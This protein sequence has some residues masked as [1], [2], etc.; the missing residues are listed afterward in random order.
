MEYLVRTRSE[1]IRQLSEL[2]PAMGFILA[3]A[4]LIYVLVGW[5]VFRVLII[6]NCAALGASIGAG[7]GGMLGESVLVRVLLAAVGAMVL[8][9]SAVRLMKAGVVLCA[10]VIGGVVGV[11]VTGVFSPEPTV[12]LIGGLLGLAGAASL[13]FVIFDHLVIAVISF[14][15]ALM[16]VAG[17]LVAIKEQGGFLRFFWQKADDS[18]FLVPFCVV[19]LTVVGICV[20]LA[21]YREGGTSSKSG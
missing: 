15:G 1:W 13:A 7:L 2:D 3:V 19:A 18:A 11:I 12:R 17:A 21:G 9:A 10:G 4:G 6:I 8:G 20:Q 16:T 14:Q 5:R